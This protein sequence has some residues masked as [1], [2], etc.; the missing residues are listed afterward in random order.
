MF[1]LLFGSEKNT[2]VERA[3]ASRTKKYF[4]IFIVSRNFEPLAQNGA[5]KWACPTIPRNS[6]QTFGLSLLL[7]MERVTGVGPVSSAWKADIIATIRYPL[8][9]KISNA[10]GF[11]LKICNKTRFFIL[12]VGGPHSNI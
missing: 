3:N 5:G 6:L 2:Y 8:G 11:Y 4:L 1:S 9:Y 7:R 12:F 10:A